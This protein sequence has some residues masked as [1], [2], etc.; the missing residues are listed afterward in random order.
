LNLVED[1][2][3]DD[4]Q[5]VGQESQ[6]SHQSSLQDRLSSEANDSSPNSQ[7]RLF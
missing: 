2:D 1:D 7:C 5:K 4:D 6:L 3:E